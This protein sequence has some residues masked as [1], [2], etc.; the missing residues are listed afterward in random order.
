MHPYLADL[1]YSQK[2]HSNK[3]KVVN[4]KK[5]FSIATV[6]IVALF[7][8]SALFAQGIVV[9]SPKKFDVATGNNLYCAGFVQSAPIAFARRDSSSTANEI[10]G[11][12]NEQDGWNYGQN[13]YLYVNAGVDKGVQV[14][15]IFSVI[16]PKGEV[17]S[18]WTK[19]GRLGVYV[20]ELGLVEVV[21]VKQS[22]SVVR[23]KTSCDSMLLGDLL[24]PFQPRVSSAYIQRPAL[25]WFGDASGK[26]TGRIFMARDNQEAVSRDQIVYVDL[27]AEDSV[28]PGD[29]LTIFRPLGKGNLFINDE[30]ESVEARI[31][32]YASSE[33]RGGKFSNQSPRKG[34]TGADKGIITT[35]KAKSDRPSGLRKVVGEGM[36]VNVRERT[37]TV[38]I[39]RVAQEIHTGDWVEIQ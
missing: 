37:A 32:D 27:G 18:R 11:A 22:V 7:S 17:E 24:V 3:E 15:D 2:C 35:E 20:Q 26:A 9:Q 30:D 21:R 28:A 14:G 13:N 34:G 39:T 10:I 5:I 33:Y 38:V 1:G 16:R 25:D 36:V 4:F 23:V 6:A 29:Y 31:S 19:K 8:A 12:Y